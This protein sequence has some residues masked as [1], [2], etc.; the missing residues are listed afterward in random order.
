[1]VVSLSNALSSGDATF[2]LVD[3]AYGQ[4][5][6]EVLTLTVP[7]RQTVQRSIATG[8]SGNWYDLTA[9][10]Q[11]E[12]CYQR[13]FMGRMETGKDGIS[14]PAMGAGIVGLWGTRTE[15]PPLP[16]RLRQIARVETKYAAV[17]KDAQ[18][19]AVPVDPKQ[20]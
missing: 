17:D 9:T 19:Y 15:H 14:D 6:D 10:V 5:G 7:A 18:F 12:S 20:L 2:T 4:L 1:V 8:A 13:R 11:S 3:N 16:A